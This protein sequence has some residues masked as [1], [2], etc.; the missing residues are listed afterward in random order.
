[1]GCSSSC[2]IFESFTT[3]I[4]WVLKNKLHVHN[5]VHFVDDFLLLHK[6]LAGCKSYLSTFEIFASSIGLPLAPDKTVGPSMTLTFLGFELSSLDMSAQIPKE[7][8]DKYVNLVHEL[9]DMDFCTLK[10]MQSAVG[11]LQWASMVIVPGRPFIRRLIDKTKFLTKPYHRISLTSEVKDDLSLWL[12]FFE[13]HNGKTLFL[14]KD[15]ILDTDTF[16]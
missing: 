10:D 5:L 9:L 4:H 12:T 3:A 11:H 16:I 8:L 1:M 14:T 15:V 6:D 13:N 7:K 2:A